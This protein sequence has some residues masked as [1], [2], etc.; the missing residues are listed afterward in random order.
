[1]PAESIPAQS[2]PWYR[3]SVVLLAACLLLPPLGIILLWMRPGMRVFRKLVLSAALGIFF[4]GHLLWFYGMR[5][6]LAG[7]GMWPLFSFSDP[8][9]HYEKLQDPSRRAGP[10]V[11]DHDQQSEA[12][13]AAAKADRA[14][15]A[16][17]AAEE[18][19]GGQAKGEGGEPPLSVEP[20]G[21]QQSAIEHVANPD[22]S[23]GSAYWTGFRGPH[24]DGHYQQAPIRANWPEAGL[25]ELWRQTVGGGYASMVVAN[26]RIFTIEQRGGDEVVAAYDLNTG[27]ELW[28]HGWPARFEE[29]MGGPGPRATPTWDAG[30][31]YALGATGELHVLEAATGKLVWKKN[32]LADNKA[33]NLHWAMSGSPLIVDDKVIVQ[34][35]GSGASIVAYDKLS[36]DAVWKSLSDTQSYTSPAE[37]TLLGQRQILTVSGDRMMGLAIEDGS[38]L[39]EFPWFTSGGGNISQPLVVDD[40]HVFISAG[41][42][43]GSALVKLARSGEAMEAAEIWQNNNLKCRFNA[44]VIHD[45]NVYGLDEGILASI[46]LWTG[47]RN[48]KGGRYGYGQLLLSG[49]HLIV[50]TEAGD[51]V[52]VRATPEAHQELT[53]FQ[54][55]D[56]KTWNNP[57]IANGKLLVRNQTEMVC[58]DLSPAG[59]T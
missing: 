16:E 53:R 8:Q 51:V 20:S 48:W 28:T 22:S 21:Q 36:G 50:L 18:A 57:A 42:G 45:G 17:L 56:G 34:P 24:R 12:G 54:A 3:S 37:V 40:E 23:A 14:G 59:S 15:S 13:S 38:L 30:K 5:M 31:V 44:P 10:A 46:D 41:Y 26:G 43:H 39:W 19:A 35:G 6:E 29:A 11:L 7:S 2:T 52:L 9:S 33:P 49:G 25:P 27:G 4:V 58:Y 47:E 55:L 32:I 1:M